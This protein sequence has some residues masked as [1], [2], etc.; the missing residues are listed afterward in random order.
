MA[1]L[2]DLG[3]KKWNGAGRGSTV[4]PDFNLDTLMTLCKWLR[5]TPELYF[6]YEFLNSC[7]CQL[8]VHLVLALTR[9]SQGPGNSWVGA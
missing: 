2:L 5:V 8:L 9:G 1:S 3:L 4:W 7:E 6:G